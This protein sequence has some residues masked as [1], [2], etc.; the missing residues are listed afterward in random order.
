MNY[1]ALLD[2]AT[3]LG[4]ELAMCGAETFRVED[5]INRILQTY[6]V[7][8]EVFAIPNCLIVSMETPDGQPMTRMRRIGYHGND[9][10][11]V[12]CFNGLSR[13]I[14]NR[15]PDPV[16]GQKWLDYVRT[17]KK[18]YSKGMYLLGN[19]LGAA[20][21]AL[22]FG[23]RFVDILWSGLC[24]VVIGLMGKFMDKLRANQFFS[25]I[26]SSFVMAVLAYTISALGLTPNVDTVIIGALMIL[27]PGLLVT[28]AMRDIIYGDTNSGVNR[29]VQVLLIA[30][31]IA[32]GTAAAWNVTGSI[33]Q[34]RAVMEAVTYPYV[35]QCIASFVGCVGFAILFNVHS[36]GIWLCAIGGM[37]TWAVYLLAF[38]LG[39]GV[40]GANFWAALFASAYSEAMARIRKYPAISYL[41]V[42][43]FPLLPGAGIYY[44]VAYALEG[45]MTEALHKGL[46]TLSIAGVMAVGILLVSTM[47]RL[48]NTWRIQKS[49]K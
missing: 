44:T 34:H 43:V 25:T 7:Q 30:M 27:V 9:L 6:G 1:N 28:N 20:G 46:Q 29:I 38:E 45:H 17:Q 26:S 5:S 10:D 32:L 24:G 41:V 21:F 15:K 35:M 48:L 47:V 14:C 16:E 18:V 11:G 3:D 4:Y 42:S 8:A 13:A 40:V 19:F 33:W 23:G 49:K 2:L 12:E 22:F 36:M 39:A 37:A 31:A